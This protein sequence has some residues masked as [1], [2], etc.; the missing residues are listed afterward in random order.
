MQDVEDSEEVPARLQ[1]WEELRITRASAAQLL[2]RSEGVGAWVLS[3]ETIE[4][5]KRFVPDGEVP[6]KFHAIV[7]ETN[8]LTIA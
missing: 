1:L 3:P 2:S 6:C 8:V 7:G 4:K 5:A